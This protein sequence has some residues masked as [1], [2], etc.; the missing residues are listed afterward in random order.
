MSAGVAAVPHTAPRLLRPGFVRVS[1][2]GQQ[3]SLYTGLGIASPSISLCSGC[4]TDAT[5]SQLFSTVEAPNVP[6]SDGS[7]LRI[8][9][10]S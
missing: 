8:E 9:N 5:C 7:V 1:G 10:F 4:G 2:H 3:F 6:L